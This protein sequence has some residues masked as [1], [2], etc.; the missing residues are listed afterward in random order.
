MA[1]SNIF[2]I[3]K[4]DVLIDDLEKTIT[5][6]PQLSPAVYS[7]LKALLVRMGGKWNSSKKNFSFKKIPSALIERVLSVGSQKLNKFHF[8]PTPKK[9]FDEIVRFTNLSFIGMAGRP[10]HVLEPSCGDGGLIDMLANYGKAEGR[11]FVIAGYDIDPLNVI[12]CQESGLNVSQADFLK[13]NPEPKFDFILA[14]P[15]FNGEEFIK[16][17]KHAQK[18]LAEDGLMVVVVPTGWIKDN[19]KTEG[20]R[21]L[22]EQAQAAGDSCLDSGEYFP[23]G[24]FDGVSIETTFICLHS[25]SKSKVTLS[26]SWYK[27]KSINAFDIHFSSSSDYYQWVTDQRERIENNEGIIDEVRDYILEIFATNVDDTINLPRCFFNDYVNYVI[28]E[29][30]PGISAS[31]PDS[32]KAESA[33][34]HF[35]LTSLAAPTIK[36]EETISKHKRKF[37][38][39]P[40]RKSTEAMP[41]QL[42]IL[43]FLNSAA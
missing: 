17:I 12:L 20:R 10:I 27:K 33:I 8:Y 2:N 14:N 32:I 31:A 37:K 29:Y 42:D 28:K 3:L 30:F 40:P 26:S 7:K 11:D 38:N 1:E 18:F 5:V 36:Q 15:P 16:H 19:N 39:N 22:L 24:T 21:W 6:I 34:S 35:E 43:D 9:I 13:V 25:I 41:D 4:N 23:V